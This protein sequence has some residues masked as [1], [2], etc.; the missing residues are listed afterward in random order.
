MATIETPDITGLKGSDRV[1]WPCGHCGGT[2]IYD[3][4]TNA[5]WDNGTGYGAWCFWCGGAKVTSVL[6]SSIRARERRQ[7]KARAEAAESQKR[8]EAARE[9]WVAAGYA[10]LLEQAEN[11]YSALHGGDPL[12]RTL[13]YAA[14]ALNL[15]T[16]TETEAIKVREALAAIENRTA[17]ATPVPEGRIE[18]EGTV[19]VVKWQ[20][21]DYGGSYKMLV[22]GTG[23]K[24]WG[25]VPSTL[26]LHGGDRVTFTAT[27]EASKDDPA[28]GFFKRPTKASILEH[29]EAV[30]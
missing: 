24:V 27:V 4:P 30:S 25:T 19:L 23:W 12:A 17:S 16:A 3:G 29:A 15:Y 5:R 14:D 22:E 6:V 9:A 10:E 28:F 2:G 20:D 1:L 8:A 18:V 11:V 13:R 7:E 26:D 21:S